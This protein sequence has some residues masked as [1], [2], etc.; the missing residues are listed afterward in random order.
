MTIGNQ[1]GGLQ[2]SSRGWPILDSYFIVFMFSSSGLNTLTISLKKSHR[3]CSTGFQMFL[4]LEVLQ[5]WS[6]DR[7]YV[8]GICNCR[9]MYKTNRTN[10]HPP[11]LKAPL[12]EKINKIMLP[13][14]TSQVSHP[15]FSISKLIGKQVFHPNDN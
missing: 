2:F 10:P 9:L 8:H 11:T 7:L 1:S 14:S 4:R 6:I 3:K 15:K 12:H 5:M 13:F